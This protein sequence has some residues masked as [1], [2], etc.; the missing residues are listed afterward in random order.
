MADEKRDKKRRVDEMDSRAI[1]LLSRQVSW[2]LTGSCEITPTMHIHFRSVQCSQLHK[3]KLP[4][5]S[6]RTLGCS[7]L[8]MIDWSC[9][10]S[11]IAHRLC[12]DQMMV[13]DDHDTM[14]T[15]FDD[16]I[17]SGVWASYLSETSIP[18]WFPHIRF[19]RNEFAVR[20]RRTVLSLCEISS[21]Y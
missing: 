9:C 17:F 8:D 4:K 12:H 6:A 14:C 21:S 1:W 20:E 2:V 15:C 19:P 5:M 11:C 3:R 13:N 10:S 18:F 7:V 16:I